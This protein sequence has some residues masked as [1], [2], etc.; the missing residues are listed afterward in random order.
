MRDGEFT[1]HLYR[2]NELFQVA[3]TAISLATATNDG[4]GTFAFSS[5]QLDCVGTYYYVVTED[6]TGALRG[7]TYDTSCYL[8]TITVSD[9]EGVLNAVTTVT[10]AYGEACTI[11]F[12]NTYLA[13][14]V[15]LLLSG[16]KVLS[17]ARLQEGAFS[18][19]LYVADENLTP[20]ATVFQTVTNDEDGKFT[21]K[22]LTF[23]SAG[24]YRYVVTEDSTAA[25]EGMVYDDTVY[26][27]TVTVADPGDGQLV[28]EAIHLTAD[29]QAAETIR[30]E[31]SYTEPEEPTIP[32]EST[33][34]GE[35]DGPD[36]SYDESESETSVDSEKTDGAVTGDNSNILLYL[37]VL[38]ISGLA[39]ILLLA[40]H[41]RRKR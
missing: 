5:L 4:A 39:V 30:F 16:K 35:S 3:D 17:G 8:V 28:I 38:A 33:D 37:I 41:H 26:G 12:E 29:G 25:I 6:S 1:F 40:D 20:Q 21:F 19:D 24:T 22:D 34:S 31:N 27:I 13:A 9:V 36:E 18:F 2:T 7:V 11:E 14:P 15:S 32:E 23:T 10:D